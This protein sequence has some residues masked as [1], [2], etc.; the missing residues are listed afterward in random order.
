MKTKN[1]KTNLNQLVKQT[2][3][4]Y[5]T[6]EKLGISA[7]YVYMLLNKEAKASPALANLIRLNLKLEEKYD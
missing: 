2:G 5:A 6:A 4:V 3:G 1:V 7:K